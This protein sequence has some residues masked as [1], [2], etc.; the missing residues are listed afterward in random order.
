MRSAIRLLTFFAYLPAY[1]TGKSAKT[2]CVHAS[3]P[4]TGS[5]RDVVLGENAPSWARSRYFIQAGGWT[6]LP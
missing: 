3:G 1:N 2:H 5:G 4:I 6:K